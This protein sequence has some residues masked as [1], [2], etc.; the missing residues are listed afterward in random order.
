MKLIPQSLWTL[1]LSLPALLGGSVFATP[2]KASPLL[3][4]NSHSM[5]VNVNKG[6]ATYY[7][8]VY[9]RHI[10][11]R[12]YADRLIITQNK[13]TGA[14]KMTAYGNPAVSTVTPQKGSKGGRAT[15]KAQKIIYIPAI[16]HLQY[17]DHA[18]LNQDGNIFKGHVINYNTEKQVASSPSSA[19]HPTTITIPP[20]DSKSATTSPTSS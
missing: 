5:V 19:A 17:L 8:N 15:G 6:T 10:N 11:H 12:L 7:K 20:Y 14:K 16:H 9:A 4:I 1:A 13:T 3:F 18:V 2:T